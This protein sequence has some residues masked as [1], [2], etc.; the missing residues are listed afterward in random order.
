MIPNDDEVL[1]VLDKIASYEQS[2]IELCS[3]IQNGYMQIS[4]AQCYSGYHTISSSS[5]PEPG[6]HKVK[7]TTLV[8]VTEES[9]VHITLERP[10]KIAGLHKRK[11]V[12]YNTEQTESKNKDKDYTS[13]RLIPLSSEPLNWFGLTTPSSLE[14]AQVTFKSALE[15]IAEICNMKK[16]LVLTLAKFDSSIAN[17]KEK[18]VIDDSDH[19]KDCD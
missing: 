4:K 1:E 2:I 15:R 9:T 8:K 14:S 5:I 3:V 13:E 11:H 17:F 7:A 6:V 19:K 16:D 18:I 12:D 10:N